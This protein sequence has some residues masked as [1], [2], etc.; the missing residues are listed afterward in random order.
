MN[1]AGHGSESATQ[2]ALF[3]WWSMAHRPFGVPETVLFSVPNGGHRNLV[4]AAR[5][6]EE[7]VRAGVP[8]IIL[9]VARGGYHG[10]FVELKRAKTAGKSKGQVSACQKMMA[11]VLR[12]QGY[13]VVV[14]YGTCEAINAIID[15]LESKDVSGGNNNA[16]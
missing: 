15:Y 11:E 6:K 16:N 4:T 1:I 8:D 10:L 14:C 7:G 9:A 13:R 2:K 3:V 5:L 12:G